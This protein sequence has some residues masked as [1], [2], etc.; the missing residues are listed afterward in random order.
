[1]QM[2][3]PTPS[4]NLTPRPGRA[5]L[6]VALCCLAGLLLMA[7]VGGWWSRD[8]P[9]FSLTPPGSTDPDIVVAQRFDLHVTFFT[10]WA[11]LLLVIPA[12]ALLP[13][14]GFSTRAGGWWLAFWTVGLVAFLVHFR[15]AVWVIFG[16]DWER[17]L[18]TPRVSAPVLDTVFAVWWCADVA[19]A[20]LWRSEALWVRVQRW[21]VHVL[22]FVLFFMGAAREGE[23]LISHLLGWTL[24]MAVALSLVARVWWAWRA[25]RTA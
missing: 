2:P 7:F 10:I 16:G 12:L 3:A 8:W 24:G 5:A 18:H 1:M 13:W 14:R 9:L 17:I 4:M 11:A 19:L 6:A 15:W 20:W 23:L 25:R 22:A 21:L